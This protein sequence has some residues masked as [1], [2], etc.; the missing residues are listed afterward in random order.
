M[1]RLELLAEQDIMS[2]LHSTH[3]FQEIY[4]KCK[5]KNEVLKSSKYI[6]LFEPHQSI[7]FSCKILEALKQSACSP[8]SC[9]PTW[10]T[11]FH[12]VTCEYRAWNAGIIPFVLRVQQ[13][14]FWYL[15]YPNT[16]WYLPQHGIVGVRIGNNHFKFLHSASIT[17]TSLPFLARDF[18]CTQRFR[19][20]NSYPNQITC[21]KLFSLTVFQSLFLLFAASKIML[22]EHICLS[23]ISDFVICM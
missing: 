9:K 6:S 20:K 14:A 4:V 21:F 11:L 13:R 17:L 2:W 19:K 16:L 1:P 22:R 18:M 8:V 3:V 12:V 5:N 10:C 7:K 15:I 23:L